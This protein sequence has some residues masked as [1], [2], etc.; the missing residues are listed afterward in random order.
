MAG[1]NIQNDPMTRAYAS[2]DISYADGKSKYTGAN[3]IDWLHRA[4]A[5]QEHET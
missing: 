3:A 1:L 4:D 2:S 5:L